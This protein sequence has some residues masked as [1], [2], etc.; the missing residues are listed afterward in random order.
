MALPVRK[1]TDRRQRGPF[2][3]FHVGVRDRQS[4]DPKIVLTCPF[5]PLLSVYI[6]TLSLSDV[7]VGRS[8]SLLRDCTTST[9]LV[10]AK[11]LRKHETVDK[12]TSPCRSA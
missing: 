4:V 1:G 3:D 7:R 10:V 12:N 5:F 8:S 9:D 6:V 11:Q 2:V